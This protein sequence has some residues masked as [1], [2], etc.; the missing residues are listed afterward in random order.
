MAGALLRTAQEADHIAAGLQLFLDHIPRRETDIDGCIQEL[1]ALS[2]A[3]KELERDFPDYNTISSRITKDVELNVMSLRFTFRNVRIMFGE[4]K[5]EK[6]S[7][8][9]PWRRAWEE[10]DYHLV[11]KEGGTSLLSRLET[12]SIFMQCILGSLKGYFSTILAIK[13]VH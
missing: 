2:S 9:R 11:E 4:T 6:Y 5:S 3:F 13:I 8:Q 7:G 1:L 10:L 12:Y